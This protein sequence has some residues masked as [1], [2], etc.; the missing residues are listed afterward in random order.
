MFADE[1][2]FGAH[3]RPYLMRFMPDGTLDPSIDATQFK[4]NY[5]QFL[6]AGAGKWLGRGFNSMLDVVLKRLDAKFE[7]DPTFDA[8]AALVG[9]PKEFNA[10]VAPDDSVFLVGTTGVNPPQI[11]LRKLTPTGAIDTTFGVGGTV[12]SAFPIDAWGKEVALQKDGKILV[13]AT[14]GL[15]PAVARFA[16]D[17]TVDESYGDKGIVTTT[18]TQLSDIRQLMLDEQG[19][20]LVLA[21]NFLVA[22]I[23]DT[24]VMDQSF[25]F[26]GVG[27]A[28]IPKSS[29]E[30]AHSK[31]MA[32]QPDGK[33]VL[34][35]T[36]SMDP[37]GNGVPNTGS[38]VLSRMDTTGKLDTSFG[39]D[40]AARIQLDK[41][42]K[43]SIMAD[44][45]G[46]ISLP[47]GRLAVGGL[48]SPNFGVE[49]VIAVVWQ[50][51]SSWVENGGQRVS[52][53]N[54]DRTDF[55]VDAS[56]SVSLMP[57]GTPDIVSDRRRSSWPKEPTPCSRP[58][59]RYCMCAGP[60]ALRARP[61]DVRQ[62]R[63]IVR[64]GGSD[65]RT[66]SRRST[67]GRRSPRAAGRSSTAS[68]PMASASS[69]PC[70]TRRRPPTHAR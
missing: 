36:V 14:S 10:T 60:R 66:R 59:A 18:G 15:R 17:G 13:G 3:M 37:D 47:D 1:T 52:L 70:R 22:R 56:D 9:M 42:G 26:N 2:G 33:L 65:G 12:I 38:A 28:S 29:G 21:S 55:R 51:R 35:G 41:A 5:E 50:W 34:G 40:G 23:L 57:S 31:W 44:R 43:L 16:A 6:P 62:S 58:T 49:G 64:A 54:G 39:K 68:I 67:R 53:G 25:G 4:G 48:E 7:I 27:G 63:S 46:V 30:N 24:G 69:S 61:F 32:L 19:R 45:Q 20:A 11:I 8:T